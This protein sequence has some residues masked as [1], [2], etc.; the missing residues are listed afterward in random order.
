MRN[1]YTTSTERAKLI[2]KFH[3]T[4]CVHS[5]RKAIRLSKEPCP[6]WRETVQAGKCSH[7][8]KEGKNVQP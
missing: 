2:K 1:G 4:K 6:Y 5:S 8:V 7:R 3:C